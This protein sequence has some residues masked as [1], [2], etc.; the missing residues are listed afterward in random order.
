MAKLL[1]LPDRREDGGVG[2]QV[3]PVPGVVDHR[4]A[5][6]HV[7][8]VEGAAPRVQV[9]RREG[10]ETRD[11]GRVEAAPLGHGVQGQGHGREQSLALAEGQIVQLAQGGGEVGLGSL[12]HLL[13]RRLVPGVKG[14][15][16]RG[17]KESLSA[18]LDLVPQPGDVLQGDLRLRGHGA[19]AFQGEGLGRLEAHLL[20]LQRPRRL[21][22]RYRAD[23]DCQVHRR[24]GCHQPLEEAGGQRA[25]PLAQVEGA[26][27]AGADAHVAPAHLHLDGGVLVE[28]C[29]G[30][31][32]GGRYEEHPK[33][34]APQG[35]DRQPAPG[36][37]APQVV[38]AGELAHGV[39]APVEDA[40][41]RL[42]VGE[43]TPQGLGG[44]LRLRGQVLR[45][46]L[47]QLLPHPFQSRRVLPDEQ[48]G[49]EVQGVERPGEGPELRL[50]YF[51]AHHLADAELHPVLAHR[52][53]L[54]EMRQHEEQRRLRRGLG[55]GW[56][57][58]A[59]G[60]LVGSGEV[61]LRPLRSSSCQ[62]SN[63]LFQQGLFLFSRGLGSPPGRSSAARPRPWPT[64][65]GRGPPPP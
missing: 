31:A 62:S 1:P 27:K 47:L 21:L 58:C 3:R 14:H 16:Q 32:Q 57:D 64:G 50:V 42:K 55:R 33:L 13:E 59:S 53:V 24:S 61:F 44:R 26:R 12:D 63:K 20:P 19:P 18:P 65:P 25:G 23:V 35:V 45:L 38:D 36:E 22:R 10:E 28:L 51:E 49:R 34:A 43:Q 60:R 5:G 11:A 40:V 17:V 39:E 9:R 41:P 6:P 4:G 30:A 8:A 7:D 29:G 46:G 56:L 54:F 2:V 37:Q 48:L 52:P 15:G